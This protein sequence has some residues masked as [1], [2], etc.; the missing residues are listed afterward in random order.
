M[1]T[2]EQAARAYLDA[3]NAHD[4]RAIVDTFAEGGTYEDPTTGGPI[5]GPAISDNA[6]LLWQAFPDFSFDIVRLAEAG[7]I[8]PSPSGR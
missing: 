2:T 7:P 8:W 1:M 4:G 5:S 3:W 6:A